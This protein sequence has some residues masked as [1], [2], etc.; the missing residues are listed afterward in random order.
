[1]YAGRI[2]KQKAP[3]LMLDVLEQTAA[4]VGPLGLVIVGDGRLKPAVRRGAEAR[5]LSG[6]VRLI[7]PVTRRELAGIYH[8]CDVSLCTSWF[9]AGPR[10]V[11]ESL[12]CGLP[13]VSFDVG[14]VNQ[15]LDTSCRTGYLVA[16]RS[17]AE[18]AKG[19]ACVLAVPTSD[20]RARECA[21]RVAGFTPQAALRPILAAYERIA[22]RRVAGGH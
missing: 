22:E 3:I 4:R 15:V 16:E 2:E 7:P 10:H 9:E 11:F 20:E 19:L 18:F 1:V 14:Q 5:G 6:K 17:P 12:A 8:A 21:E 13:V